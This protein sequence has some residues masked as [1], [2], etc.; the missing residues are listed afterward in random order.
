MNKAQRDK[1]YYVSLSL[2]APRNKGRRGFI[3]GGGKCFVSG[4]KARKVYEDLFKK[5]HGRKPLPL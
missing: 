2:L 1:A 4:P 5:I 3:A